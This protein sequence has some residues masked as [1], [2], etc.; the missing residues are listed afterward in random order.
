MDFVRHTSY[1]YYYYY[2]NIFISC[3]HIDT[4]VWK[5]EGTGNTS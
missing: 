1:Y 2:C 4:K 3:E 5:M